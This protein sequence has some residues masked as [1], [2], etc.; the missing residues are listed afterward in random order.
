MIERALGSDCLFD[1]DITFMGEDEFFNFKL[2]PY[3]ASMFISDKIVYVYRWGGGTTH[4]NPHFNELF[5][6]S[7]IR[8]NY[9]D[10]FKYEKGYQPLFVEYKN[11]L[12]TESVQR[13]H[14]L[15]E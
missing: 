3:L 2:F 15:G 9:L 4:F 6:F 8:I 1:D 7:D 5:H 13:I 14:Y 11:M 12:V 10:K